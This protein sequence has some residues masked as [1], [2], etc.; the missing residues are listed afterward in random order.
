VSLHRA[1]GDR[2]YEAIALVHLADTQ[3]SLRDEAAA[4]DALAIAARIFG[5][6]GHPR[7]DE[8]RARLRTLTA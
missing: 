8:V 4:R 3:V 5:E 1:A 2:Y 7:A 6:L